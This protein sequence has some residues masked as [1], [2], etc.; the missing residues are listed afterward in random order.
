MVKYSLYAVT[1]LVK[2]EE[3]QDGTGF[4]P[5]I[6]DKYADKYTKTDN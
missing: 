4:E 3:R 2:F 1:K 6:H 5:S